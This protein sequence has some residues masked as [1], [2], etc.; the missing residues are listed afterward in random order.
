MSENKTPFQLRGWGIRVWNSIDRFETAVERTIEEAHAHGITAIDL[1]DGTIPPG[2]GWIDLFA[3]YKHVQALRDAHVLTYHGH[4]LTSEQR[5]EYRIRFRT[6]CQKIKARGLD[7]HVWYHVLRDLPQ[8]WLD[9]EPTV[10][11]LE[12]RRLWQVLGGIVDDFLMAVPEVDALT[13]TG[14]QALTAGMRDTSSVTSGER[15]RAIYQCLYEACRRQRRRLIIREVGT[16]RAETDAFLH[17]IGPLPPDI[18]IMLKDVQGD[19]Y[20]LDAPPNPLFLHLRNKQVIVETDLFGVHWGHLDVPL[21]RPRQIRTAIR[22]WLLH[23]V[24]GVVARIKVIEQPDSPYEH[25]FAT[26]NEA[27]IAVF[28]HLCQHPY[29]DPDLSATDADAFDFSLWLDWLHRRY[30]DNAS[31]DVIA[32]LDRTPN[33]VHRVFYLGGVYFQDRSYLPTPS[34]FEREL[35]P[36]FVR[37]AERLGTDALQWEKE[38]ALRLVRQS[39]RDIELAEPTLRRHDYESLI[40]SFEK[41]R[42]VTLAYRVFIDLCVSRLHPEQMTIT[43]DEALDL[44]DRIETTRGPEFFGHLPDRLRRLCQYMQDAARGVHVYH[45]EPTTV[46]SDVDYYTDDIDIDDL[47]Y[48]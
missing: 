29:P 25:L 12:G 48:V 15:L 19:W 8:E 14:Q 2:I 45:E 38:I 26:P 32:A 11:R 10:S 21:Y 9:A 24:S 30:G 18:A 44:A 47:G 34:A 27:N 13:V 43:M 20:H 16:T 39:L 42:D 41:A 33:I 28:S 22:S 3:E 6:L 4:P 7:V 36:V 1:H 17:A 46:R 40:Q 31:P 5:H 35:W 37:Q 23:S